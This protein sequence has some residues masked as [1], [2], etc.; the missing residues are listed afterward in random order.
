M[1]AISIVAASVLPSSSAIIRRGI[2]GATITQGQAIYVDSANSYV[3]K[4]TT[5]AS[6]L[7]AGSAGIGIALNAASSGQPVDYVVSDP[8]FTP[9]STQLSGDDV[10]LFDTTAG[11]LTITKGDLESGDYVTHMGTY[12][13]TT[14]MNLN[15][16]LGGLI[17]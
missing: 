13:S 6:A 17:A 8:A 3:L 16:T 2:A 7:A 15:P 4:L 5:T 12:I 14:T 1:A 11:A 10:W 9:G